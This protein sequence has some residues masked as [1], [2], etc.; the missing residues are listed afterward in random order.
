LQQQL[1]FEPTFI[2]GSIMTARPWLATFLLILLAIPA[3]AAKARQDEPPTA[4]VL[5]YH[6]VESPQDPRMEVS[7][8][9]FRQQMRYLAMTGYNVIPLRYVYEYVSGKR[10]SLPKN[11]IVVTIDDGWRSTYT[12]VFPEMRKRNFPFTVFVYPK[13]VGQTAYALTWKQVREMSEAG[14]DIQSHS[15]S[16]P[17]L[18]H[19]RHG[20]LDDQQYEAWLLHELADSKRILQR[21]TGRDV[22]FFAYPYGDYDHHLMAAVAKAG[23]EAALTCDYGHVVRGSDP[24]R[25]RRFVVDKRMD[26]AAFRHYLGAGEMRI[27]GVTPIPGQ[28]V[29]P[30]EQPI[31]VSAK[32][33][34]YKHLDP[35]SVA[36]AVLSATV[37]APYSYD[38]RDGSISM[39]LRDAVNK[40]K[41]QYLRAL[42]WGTDAKTGKR[43][44]ATWTFRLPEPPD[45]PL[46]SPNQPASTVTPSPAGE[47]TAPR[48]GASAS[49]ASAGG[50]G[51]VK[52]SR[53]R[54]E[55]SPK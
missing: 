52:G 25:M 43:V 27:E 50:G 35:T 38:A 40:L 21:E 26:F 11:A 44:E 1:A 3:S 49:L 5:C 42:V 47:S 14:V 32:L 8:E 37:T 54:F 17:F 51:D 34:N 16:H 23:Y 12:E 22:S 2:N 39:V 55:R 29:E 7:R 45:L 53:T 33:P 48:G 30:L 15:F 10:S 20:S 13:I 28:V 31:V 9:T 18:T 19:R 36:M 41:G 24:L 6:I 46:V 4:I